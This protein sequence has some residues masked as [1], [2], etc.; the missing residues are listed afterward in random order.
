MFTINQSLTIRNEIPTTYSEFD[1]VCEK[2]KD[3]GITPYSWPE[4]VTYGSSIGSELA[5]ILEQRQ[6]P[7]GQA[8]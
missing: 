6:R 3:N 1:Q 4:T 2:L 7:N 5:Q 8:Q